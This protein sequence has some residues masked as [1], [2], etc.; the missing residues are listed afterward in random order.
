MM[1]ASRR[2]FT[3]RVEHDVRAARRIRSRAKVT[4]VSGTWPGSSAE[5]TVLDAPR[6]AARRPIPTAA[7][8]TSTASRSPPGRWTGARTASPTGS[9]RWA[10]A[11]ATGSRRC[12]RTPPSRCVSF[13]AALEA[14]RDPGADQ[15]RLQGRVPPPRPRRLRRPGDGGPGRA[16]PAGWPRLRRRPWPPTCPSC[17]RSS[18]SGRPTPRSTGSR[19]DDWAD[20]ARRREPT[21]RADRRRGPAVGP[22]VLHLH[23]GHDRPVE[24]LHAPAPLRGRAGRADRPG[25]AARAR[26]RRPHAAAAVP[27][28]RDLGVR[29]RDAASPAAARRSCASSR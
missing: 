23:R 25:L 27:L 8:W 5:T 26:R 16:W 13:F 19:S 4:V 28:Q 21:S 1:L 14:R 29:G 2:P 15:H 10:S 6:D 18:W 24:G 22:R 11:A 12:S 3:R 7:T 20:A 9:P 17:G